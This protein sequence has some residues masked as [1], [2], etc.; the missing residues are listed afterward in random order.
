MITSLKIAFK[1]GMKGRIV[2]E[3]FRGQFKGLMNN[4]SF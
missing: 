2:R 3:S 4:A 1:L